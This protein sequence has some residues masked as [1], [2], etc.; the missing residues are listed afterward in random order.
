MLREAA[1]AWIDSHFPEPRFREDFGI[2]F[3]HAAAKGRNLYAAIAPALTLD[4]KPYLMHC[5][6]GELFVFELTESQSASFQIRPGQVR[7]GEGLVEDRMIQ[8]CLSPR[9]EL[10]DL[11]IADAE[12]HALDQPIV[13]TIF[14]DA[15]LHW[16]APC[17]FR[18]DYD[19]GGRTSKVSW[20]YVDVPKAPRGQSLIAF[21]PMLKIQGAR[22]LA[23][24]ITAFLRL[25]DL[26]DPNQTHH[27]TPISNICAVL[28]NL[29]AARI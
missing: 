20:S 26:P 6:C 22:A 23:G 11:S 15:G 28:I 18:L 10:R 1:L 4:R 19:L 25:C 29:T 14:H 2:H 9:V 5:F 7:W 12:A 16:P 13:A 8:P 3:A 27:R 21:P 17:V 24:T